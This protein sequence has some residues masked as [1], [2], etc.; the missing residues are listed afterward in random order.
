M[1]ATMFFPHSFWKKTSFYSTFSSCHN[2]DM[3]C[4]PKGKRQTDLVLITKRVENNGNSPL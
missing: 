2:K 4:S 3:D 1:V